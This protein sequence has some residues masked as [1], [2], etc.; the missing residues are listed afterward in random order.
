M[1]EKNNAIQDKNDFE[2]ICQDLNN[3]NSQLKRTE[4]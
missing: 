1:Q 4:E 2:I 3:K